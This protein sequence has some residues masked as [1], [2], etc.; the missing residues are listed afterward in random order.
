MSRMLVR[1]VA[2]LAIGLFCGSAMAAGSSAPF[3]YTPDPA[4]MRETPAQLRVRIQRACV[5]T[6]AGIQGGSQGSASRGCGCYATR[7][8]RAMTPAELAAYRSTGIFDETT[9]V[10]A[11]AALDSCGLKR[12]S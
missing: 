3:G 11:F 5:S 12:P 6:Q 7:V 4:L 9:R 10:K 8:L 1:S 2:A